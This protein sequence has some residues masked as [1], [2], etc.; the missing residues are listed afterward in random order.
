M[1]AL[2]ELAKGG[3]DEGCGTCAYREGSI[4]RTEP[5]NL[6]K[7]MM[8][9]EGA[10]PFH[11]HQG[12]PFRERMPLRSELVVC[13]GWKHEVAKRAQDPAWREARHV[14]HSLAGSAMTLIDELAEA[15]EGE[16]AGITADL[17]ELTALLFKK[18]AVRA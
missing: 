11:C 17:T 7:S 5:T 8:A 3:C 9:V 2:E 15:P 4:T 6:I 16:K 14:K 10:V 13:A 1:S 18:S 12:F